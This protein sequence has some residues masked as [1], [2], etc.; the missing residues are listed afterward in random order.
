MTFLNDAEFHKLL[1]VCAKPVTLR[2]GVGQGGGVGGYYQEHCS[3]EIKYMSHCLPTLSPLKFFPSFP[4]RVAVGFGLQ[5]LGNI[6]F[7]IIISENMFF[8]LFF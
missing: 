6:A 1:N 8:L 3:E 7:L 4:K 5:I 2:E